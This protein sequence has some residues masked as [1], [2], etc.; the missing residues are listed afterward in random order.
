MVFDTLPHQLAWSLMIGGEIFVVAALWPLS[1]WATTAWR[2]RGFLV[3]LLVAL[4]CVLVNLRA[5]AP[6]RLFADPVHVGQVMAWFVVPLFLAFPGAV[7]VA[8]GQSLRHAGVPARPA[9]I[10][11]LTVAALTAL[12]APL[13]AMSAACVLGGMC[14]R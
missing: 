10:V 5:F 11:A 9:R 3:A 2:H 4:A 12:V 7:C 1:E 6:A 14:L 13:A 8:S